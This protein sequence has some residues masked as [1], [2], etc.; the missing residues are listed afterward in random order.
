MVEKVPM[1]AEGHER[2]EA[3]LKSLK[4]EQRPAVIK[5][6]E[7]AR[8][9]GDLSEN[10]EYHAAK[11]QQGFIESRISD[12]EGKVSRA[13]VFDPKELSGDKVLFAATVSMADEDDKIVKYQIV[14]VD[15]VDVTAGK[16]SYIS[17]IG[18]ALIGRKVGDEIE[19]KTPKGETYYEITNVEFI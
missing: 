16:I 12:I 19:V 18:R 8:A 14:G 2:L 6:I 7:E 15:E 9:H 5:A 10:A 13:E 3:D 17:P 11:E 4:H 1:T